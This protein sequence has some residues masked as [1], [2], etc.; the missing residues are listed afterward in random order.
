[1]RLPNMAR[2][3]A[4]K[5]GQSPDVVYRAI[6]A[7]MESVLDHTANGERVDLPGFGSFFATYR[8]GGRVI[9]S[10]TRK[11]MVVEPR[12]YLKFKSRKNVSEILWNRTKYGRVLESRGA[13]GPLC[14]PRSVKLFNPLK[15]TKE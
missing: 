8:K 6:L 3:I 9:N 14:S 15:D 11:P 13:G 2:I 4:A 12:L 7:F 5:Q 1:M 10:F